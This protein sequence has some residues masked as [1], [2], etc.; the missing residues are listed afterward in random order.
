MTKQEIIDEINHF[1]KRAPGRKEYLEI[2]ETG[3][4]TYAKAV[5]ALC[6]DC[7]GYCE[8]G[9][10]DCEFETCPL[11]PVSPYRPK[12]GDKK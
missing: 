11:F 3:K 5:R 12:D 6:Y 9:R 7:L 2:L 1:G 10:I 4:T 8:S